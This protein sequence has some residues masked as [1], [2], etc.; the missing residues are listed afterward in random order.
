MIQ[1]HTTDIWAFRSFSS[2]KLLRPACH[3]YAQ[4]LAGRLFLFPVYQLR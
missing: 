4:A 3:R 1:A 2:R